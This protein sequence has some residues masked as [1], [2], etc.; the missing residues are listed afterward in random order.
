VRSYQLIRLTCELARALRR[1]PPE[2]RALLAWLPQVVVKWMVVVRDIQAAP[3][4]DRQSGLFRDCLSAFQ[5]A[6]FGR[7]FE[8]KERK[9]AIGGVKGYCFTY[10]IPAENW[11]I[12]SH[13]N[14][15][16][17]ITTLLDCNS[18]ASFWKVK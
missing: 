5:L 9:P 14:L 18:L 8:D 11:S 10:E 7:I 12:S 3:D 6:V 17:F 4:A 13:S 1:P 16:R 2:N 15:Q